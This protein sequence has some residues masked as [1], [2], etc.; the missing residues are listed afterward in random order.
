MRNHL[1]DEKIGDIGRV[2]GTVGIAYLTEDVVAIVEGRASVMGIPRL[3]Q[4]AWEKGHADGYSDG[5]WLGRD[6]LDHL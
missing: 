3:M 6:I 1:D 5:Y 4:T 2:L